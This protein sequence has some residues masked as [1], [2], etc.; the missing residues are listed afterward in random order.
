MSYYLLQR[1]GGEP[2]AMNLSLSED[3]ARRYEGQLVLVRALV[4]W[5]D[6]G[7]L[8]VFRVGLRFGDSRGHCADHLADPCHTPRSPST[9]VIRPPKRTGPGL[10]GL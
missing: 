4:V 1:E 10:W 7:N 9:L 3:E 6:L 8:V 2:Y 5:T